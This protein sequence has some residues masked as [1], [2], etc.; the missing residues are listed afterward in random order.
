[1]YSTDLMRQLCRE[2]TAEKDPHRVEELISLLRAVIRDDQEEI[3]TRMGL[4][5]KEYAGVISNSKAAD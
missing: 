1:V 4:L 2:I 3:R 5:A